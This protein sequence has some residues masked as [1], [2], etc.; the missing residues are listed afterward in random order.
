MGKK[1]R[2]TAAAPRSAASAPR[3]SLSPST[4]LDR[5]PLSVAVPLL[6][7]VFVTLAVVS[8]RGKGTAFDETSHL[9]AGYTYWKTG[10]F[11]MNPEH[12]PLA[13]LWA[14]LPLLAMDVKLSSDWKEWQDGK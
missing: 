6:L 10:D 1:T 5:V 3:P 2:S 11:R 14:A 12:P 8:M 7:A 4:V 9:P 13:K